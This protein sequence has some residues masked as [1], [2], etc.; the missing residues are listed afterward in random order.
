VLGRK[1]GRECVEH[2]E[3]GGLQELRLAGNRCVVWEGV[4]CC[5]ASMA[6]NVCVARGEGG[7]SAGAAAGRQQVWCERGLVCIGRGCTARVQDRH[8]NEQAQAG[9]PWK[10]TGEGCTRVCFESGY[11]A[12][13]E[14]SA[15]PG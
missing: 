13:A 6:G 4:V 14:P 9:M 1:Y 8:A 11:G 12:M 3:E 15:H 7:G 10:W 5:N 2:R